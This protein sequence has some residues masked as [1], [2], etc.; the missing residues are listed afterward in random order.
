MVPFVVP[1]STTLAPITG[2]LVASTTVPVIVF[3]CAITL[4]DI[5]RPNNKKRFFFIEL[6]ISD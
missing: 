2:S 3:V 1:A 6:K 4:N 5:K